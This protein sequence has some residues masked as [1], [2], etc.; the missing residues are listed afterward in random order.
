MG[1]AK[2]TYDNVKNAETLRLRTD[3]LAPYCVEFVY[4]YL[5]GQAA[6]VSVG[7]VQQHTAVSLAAS[8]ATPTYHCEEVD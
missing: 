3:S 8:K 4:Y 5:V 6:V 7:N 2:S 1:R